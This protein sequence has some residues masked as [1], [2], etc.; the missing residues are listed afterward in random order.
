[1]MTFFAVPFASISFLPLSLSRY[2]RAQPYRQ[3][4]D[5]HATDHVHE[6]QPSRTIPHQRERFPL[7]ARKRRV[8]SQKSDHQQQAP[9][10]MR[11][12]TLRQHRHNKSDQKRSADIYNA[13]AE[14][15]P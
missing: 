14:R 5:H 15:E 9:V 1:M 6:A 13:R 10:G 8:A 4:S 2:Y 12:Q 11:I 3:V 7:E